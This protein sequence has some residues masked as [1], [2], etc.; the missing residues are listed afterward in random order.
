MPVPVGLP[1]DEAAQRRRPDIAEATGIDIDVPEIVLEDFNDIEITP[2]Q[3]LSL[4][5]LIKGA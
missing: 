5:W 1:T 3:F 2:K 4:K